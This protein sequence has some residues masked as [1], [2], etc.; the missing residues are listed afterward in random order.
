MDEPGPCGSN[1]SININPEFEIV[2]TTIQRKAHMWQQSSAD[3]RESS[4]HE[5]VW[6]KE[7]SDSEKWHKF[8]TEVRDARNLARGLDPQN[9]FTDDEAPSLTAR[10]DLISCFKP[11]S[12]LADVTPTSALDCQLRSSVLWYDG[13]GW[14]SITHLTH[15]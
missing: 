15:G 2:S 3:Y 4:G 14:V 6:P 7:V 13:A 8:C 12:T 5:P 11:T 9:A 10:D 1:L